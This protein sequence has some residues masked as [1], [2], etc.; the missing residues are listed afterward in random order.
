MLYSGDL[1]SGHGPILNGLKQ[2]VCKWSVFQIGP[3]I[4]KPYQLKY[5]QIG[6]H[7]VKLFDILSLRVLEVLEPQIVIYVNLLFGQ[8]WLM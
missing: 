2:S 5:R 1:K 6:P 3:E 7:F 8:I 4:R